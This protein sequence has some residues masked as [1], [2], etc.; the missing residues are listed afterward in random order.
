MLVSQKLS[1]QLR[2]SKQFLEST[3]NGLS[4]NIALINAEGEIVL[5][6]Q[7]WRNFAAANGMSQ[8]FVSEGVNYL[9]VCEGVC[10]DNALEA[11][12]FAQG[13]RDVL[14]GKLETFSMYDYT[15]CLSDSIEGITHSLCTLEFINN[16][17]LYDWVLETLGAYRPQQIE[18]A[19]LNVTYTV[20]SKRKLIQ[21]VK[22]GHV[23]GWDDPRM[24]RASG[25]ARATCRWAAGRRGFL[26]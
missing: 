4:A 2:S 11:N 14:D 26:T 12:S 7:A 17:E 5:V 9:R 16:R 24:R 13:I 22:E 1:D 23:T 25:V 8:D 3:L 19:R 20:L 6:N 10:A 21:L 18:F 15:H